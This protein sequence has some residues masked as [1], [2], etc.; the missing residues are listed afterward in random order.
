MGKKNP[1]FKIESYGIYS[2]WNNNS[3]NL[4]KIKEFTLEVPSVV[5]TEFGY[6]LNIKGGKSEKIDFK[7][8]HP[9]FKDYN[10]EISPPFTGEIFI[11]SNNYNIYLGDCIWEPTDDK[12]GNWK[13]DTFYKGKI[14]L[15]K[16]FVVV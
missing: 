13:I 14:I 5:G 8:E 4:P 3:K 6:I 7:I 10:N 9:P 12:K 16:T 1:E 11:N 15:S 2:K